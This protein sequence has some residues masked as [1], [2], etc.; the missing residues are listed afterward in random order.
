[1]A[2]AMGVAPGAMAADPHFYPRHSGGCVSPSLH[3]TAIRKERM[4]G[5]VYISRRQEDRFIFVFTFNP[6]EK[7]SF[8]PKHR[9]AIDCHQQQNYFS[10]ISIYLM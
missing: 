9:A 6:Q 5:N 3:C 10:H 1:M 8:S 7:K 4:T 2:T